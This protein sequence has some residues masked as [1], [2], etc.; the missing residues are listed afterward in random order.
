MSLARRRLPR[1][2]FRRIALAGRCLAWHPDGEIA[3]E[4]EELEIRSPLLLG[5]ER[6]TIIR[7]RST[8]RTAA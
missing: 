3:V 6:S 7:S 2:G 8:R 1:A 5:D 4:I